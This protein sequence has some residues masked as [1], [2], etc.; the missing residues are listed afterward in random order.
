MPTT[1]KQT[2]LVQHAIRIGTTGIATT[3]RPLTGLNT[4]RPK[5]IMGDAAKTAAAVELS[6]QTGVDA[7]HVMISWNF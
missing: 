5:D 6:K 3:A 1:Y 4:G 2:G 7:Q